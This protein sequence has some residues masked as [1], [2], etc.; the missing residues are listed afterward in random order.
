MNEVLLS[1]TAK[2]KI[3]EYITYFFIYSFLGWILETIYA[4]LVHGHYVNRG[5]LISPFCPI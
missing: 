5:F 1:K 2:D 4:F 3:I